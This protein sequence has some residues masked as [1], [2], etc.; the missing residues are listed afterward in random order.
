VRG[1]YGFSTQRHIRG[2]AATPSTAQPQNAKIFLY[3]YIFRRDNFSFKMNKKKILH[4]VAF[5]SQKPRR[6]SSVW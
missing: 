3:I 1:K 4:F 2:V 6:R 5:A